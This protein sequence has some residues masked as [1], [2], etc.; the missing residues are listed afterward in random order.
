MQIQPT[1]DPSIPLMPM[2]VAL[3]LLPFSLAF[4]TRINAAEPGI[5]NLLVLSILEGKS[6]LVSLILR[7]GIRKGARFKQLTSFCFL[8]IISTYVCHM[9]TAMVAHR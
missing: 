7:K 2:L 6:R 8:F 5:S 4:M 9:S 3:E 1:P